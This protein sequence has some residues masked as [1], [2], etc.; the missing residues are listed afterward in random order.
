[1]DFSTVDTHL[2]LWGS[3]SAVLILVGLAGTV[4]PA[5]PGTL[6]ILGGIVLFAWAD[7]FKRIGPWTLV[8]VSVLALLA[9]ATDFLAAV[10]GARRVGASRLALL[11]AA[12]GMLCG[13]FTGFVGLLFMPLVGAVIGEWIAGRDS[14]RAG[15]VGIATWLGMLVGTV[16]KL[17]L[18][19]LMIGVFLAALFF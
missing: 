4:L 12:L 18:S 13:V 1:M 3:A 5:L 17:V 6:F 19:F 9:W 7:D 11:G 2:L 14:L 15:K 10:L 8:G 16:I